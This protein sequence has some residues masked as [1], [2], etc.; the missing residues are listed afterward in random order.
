MITAHG[1]C[2]SV[3][4]ADLIASLIA[5]QTHSLPPKYE[6]G[7][8]LAVLVLAAMTTLAGIARFI[9]IQNVFTIAVLVL[10]GA[11]G[12][13]WLAAKGGLPPIQFNATAVRDLAVPLAWL[14]F[15]LASRGVAKLI[16]AKMNRHSAVGIVVLV[17]AT[18]L[19]TTLS[20][21]FAQ[22]APLARI[23]ME[24]VALLV[25]VAPWLINKRPAAPPPDVHPLWVWLLMDL[26]LTA[27]NARHHLWPA[28]VAGVASGVFVFAA[29]RTGL[30]A[31]RRSRETCASGR[32]L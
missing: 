9:P 11:A 18:T 15:A 3:F 13:E 16:A 29:A 10:C 24:P 20:H 19:A 2:F 4:V 1:I 17:I 30:R 21:S 8:N 25:L 12:M 28:T 5:L 7:L 31:A 27:E 22:S 23:A 26:F 32:F 6:E 14:V